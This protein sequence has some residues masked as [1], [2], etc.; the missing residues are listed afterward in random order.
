[1][2]NLNILIK[3]YYLPQ[4]IESKTEEIKRLRELSRSIPGG[5]P[6]REFIPGGPQVQCRFAEIIDKVIDLEGE[7]L[8]EI[9]ELLDL[10]KKAHEIINAV[11]DNTERLILQYYYIDRLS[12]E[13]IA[14]EISYTLRQTQRIKKKTLEKIQNIQIP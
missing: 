9:N 13:E 6:S 1:M 2:N 14:T 12:M 10:Q 4:L 5:D 11:Q 8:D 3:C 7:I